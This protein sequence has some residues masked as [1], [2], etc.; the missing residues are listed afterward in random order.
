[1]K[2][3]KVSK[4]VFFDESGTD[5]GSNYL[6]LGVA[7]CKH[8]SELHEK[9]DQLRK[10]HKYHNEI[11]FEKMSKKRYKIYCAFLRVFEDSED[12]Y[13]KAVV[14]DKRKVGVEHFSH[15][16]WVRFNVL[17]DDLVN[18]VVEKNEL[19]KIIADE[20]TSPAEDNFSEYLLTHVIGARE[21][22][23][24]NSKDYDLV[25]M[26]D[27]ILGAVRANF[28]K[29]VKNELKLK[30][31]DEVLNFPEEKMAYYEYKNESGQPSEAES[32]RNS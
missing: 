7:V 27:L 14:V 2:T 17:A 29:V 25:Q 10:K 8:P 31:I 5:G 16:R 18:S 23:L 11:K 22:V 12:V 28:E 26:C 3:Q 30:I 21:V 4:Y 19:V 13:F 24:V 9:F 15:K 6:A 1:M 32:G 20:K